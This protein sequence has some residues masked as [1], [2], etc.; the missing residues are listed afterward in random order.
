MG[1]ANVFLNPGNRNASQQSTG[2]GKSIPVT[3]RV[4]PVNSEEKVPVVAEDNV[5]IASFSNV[6]EPEEKE[7]SSSKDGGDKVDGE[8]VDVSPFEQIFGIASAVINSLNTPQ[9]S[10]E[11]SEEPDVKGKSKATED[12]GESGFKGGKHSHDRKHGHGRKGHESGSNGDAKHCRRREHHGSGGENE[13]GRKGC[14][15]RKVH[16]ESKGKRQQ[17]EGE[18]VVE[19]IAGIIGSIFG[20]F[21]P[22]QQSRCPR[23]QDRGESAQPTSQ[24]QAQNHSNSDGKVKADIFEKNENKREELSMVE[25]LS[26]KSEPVLEKGDSKDHPDSDNDSVSSNLSMVERLKLKS[27]PLVE[28]T[29]FDEKKTVDIA[30]VEDEE[31]VQESSAGVKKEGS[32]KAQIEKESQDTISQET[33]DGDWV[34]QH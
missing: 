8:T 3:V 27:V 1:L 32:K 34:V 4:V 20:A 21:D 13:H 15:G 18:R 2:A 30:P 14:P 12:V 23:R 16:D 26:L 28:E 22:N 6:N 9:P 25:K 29:Q 5:K 31:I 10:H 7:I 11:D 19:D 17:Y 24:T 33:T